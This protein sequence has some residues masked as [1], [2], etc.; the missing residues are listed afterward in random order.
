MGAFRLL[1]PLF[2]WKQK[3]LRAQNAI[4]QSMSNEFSEYL[5]DYL[6]KQSTNFKTYLLT[7]L[8]NKDHCISLLASS[9]GMIYET[10]DLRNFELL[11]DAKLFEEKVQFSRSGRN[12]YKIFC[13]TELGLKM[14]EDLKKDD[15]MAIQPS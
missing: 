4:N 1:L 8:E 10:K 6:K 14:A 15:M 2:G 11:C 7:A 9:G 13:L 3:N 5:A 12:S